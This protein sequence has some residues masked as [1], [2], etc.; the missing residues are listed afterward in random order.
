MARHYAPMLNTANAHETTP[1]ENIPSTIQL[2]RRPALLRA[3]KVS[4]PTLWRWQREDET[5]P[6]PVYL[7][8]RN[9]AW[10]VID[11]EQWLSQRP[12]TRTA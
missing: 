6:K 7:T 5:F 9:P 8:D 11:I 3:L 10:R 1:A 12:T 2:I 4:G